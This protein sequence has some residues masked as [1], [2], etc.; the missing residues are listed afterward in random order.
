[1]T[2]VSLPQLYIQFQVLLSTNQPNQQSPLTNQ[3]DQQNQQNQAQ[4][5]PPT[6]QPNQQRQQNQARIGPASRADSASKKAPPEESVKNLRSTTALFH[7]FRPG[8]EGSVFLLCVKAKH[9]CFCLCVFYCFL[10]YQY[11]HWSAPLLKLNA[12]ARC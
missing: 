3:P 11:Y 1:M 6:N 4:Q 10:R 2:S 8:G 7:F 9:A 12:L 5:K